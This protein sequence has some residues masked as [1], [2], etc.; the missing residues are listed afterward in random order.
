MEVKNNIEKFNDDFRFQLTKEKLEALSISKI[1]TS[2]QT[3]GIKG[4]HAKLPWNGLTTTTNHVMLLL[5]DQCVALIGAGRKTR[6]HR[7]RGGSPLFL[8]LTLIRGGD[9]LSELSIF[10]DESGDFNISTSSAI[11]EDFFI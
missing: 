10:I 2:I 1:L 11:A 5:E 4:G 3:K 8:L 7:E 6:V 9:A